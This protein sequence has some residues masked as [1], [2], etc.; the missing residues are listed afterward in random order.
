MV[1][2]LNFG[3]FSQQSFIILG[4]M[5]ANTTCQHLHSHIKIPFSIFKTGHFNDFLLNVH[6]SISFYSVAVNFVEQC[7]PGRP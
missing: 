4:A 2:C 3:P 5:K 1:Q 7:A 6:M